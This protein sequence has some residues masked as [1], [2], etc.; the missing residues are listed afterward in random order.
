MS[1]CFSGLL[2][3]VRFGA[4]RLDTDEFGAL[5]GQSTESILNADY[6]SV[7]LY[8]DT[9]LIRVVIGYTGECCY[10]PCS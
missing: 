2:Y 10:V 1:C 7:N 9:D 6:D 4:N 5:I 8:N 3:T